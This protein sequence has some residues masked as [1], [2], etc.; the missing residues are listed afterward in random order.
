[1]YLD[2]NTYRVLAEERVRDWRREAARDRLASQ[3]AVR[4]AERTCEGL[5]SRILRLLSPDHPRSVPQP[6]RRR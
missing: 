4:P 2:V 3:A 5:F 1:M 6:I